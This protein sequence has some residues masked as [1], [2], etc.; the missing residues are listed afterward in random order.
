MDLM[1][2][3][4]LCRPW[5]QQRRIIIGEES[6]KM[7]DTREKMH[8]VAADVVPSTKDMEMQIYHNTT[9]EFPELHTSV[10]IQ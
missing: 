3:P 2:M 10:I 5:K 6:L 9:H 1:E 4:I 8:V 7:P